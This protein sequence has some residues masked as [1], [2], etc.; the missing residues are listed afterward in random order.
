MSKKK[1]KALREEGKKKTAPLFGGCIASSCRA[2]S[3]GSE[4]DL[5]EQG[6]QK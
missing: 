1:G 3:P 4:A 2:L 6:Y 5:K